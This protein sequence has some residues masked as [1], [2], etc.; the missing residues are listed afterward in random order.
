M[1]ENYDLKIGLRRTFTTHLVQ[2]S[3]Q[4]GI[5]YAFCNCQQMFAQSVF[6]DSCD[7]ECIILLKIITF[8]SFGVRAFLY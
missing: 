3:A 1:L 2:P 4:G 6:K 7:G 8:A 5:R